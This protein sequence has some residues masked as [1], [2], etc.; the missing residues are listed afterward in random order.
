MGFGDLQSADGLRS[1]NAF[2]VDKSYVE[3]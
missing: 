2:L 3:G 1:L